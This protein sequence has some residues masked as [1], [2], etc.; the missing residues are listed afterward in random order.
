MTRPQ[1][2]SALSGT[3][4]SRRLRWWQGT[5]HAI[6]GG[7]IPREVGRQRSVRH[8]RVCLA[9]VWFMPGCHQTVLELQ[10]FRAFLGCM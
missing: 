5:L 3:W 9:R 7:H 2:R 1:V 4:G 8:L 6:Q 10:R